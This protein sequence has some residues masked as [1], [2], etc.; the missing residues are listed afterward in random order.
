MTSSTTA[1]TAQPEPVRRHPALMRI[2][3]WGTAVLILACAVVVL[4]REMI[5]HQQ[6]RQALLMVHRQ[7]G[8]L[9]LIALFGRLITRL[10]VGLVDHAGSVGKVTRIL[11]GLAHWV[12]YAAIGALTVIG[13]ALTNAHAVHL[14]LL[15]VIPLPNLVQADSDLADVLSDWHVAIAWT[16]LGLVV[17]HVSAAL[18]HHFR[19][20]DSV[21]VAMLPGPR[22]ARPR[23]VSRGDG[24][25]RRVFWS[26]LVSRRPG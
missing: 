17:L 5:E 11:A 3:H 4:S 25:R 2:F 15:E 24:G 14:R 19:L 6:A 13:W 10:R 22:R 1:S 8:L 9:V 21:L 23:A 12:M 16:L 20:R 26:H 18:W 7:L